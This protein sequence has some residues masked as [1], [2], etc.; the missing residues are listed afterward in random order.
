MGELLVTA[1]LHIKTKTYSL[2]VMY[3]CVFNVDLKPMCDKW[4]Y[5]RYVTYHACYV[6]M[7]APKLRKV[8]LG[9]TAVTELTQGYIAVSS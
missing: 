3:S 4:M 5:T 6:Q 1:A 7:Y 2:F 9:D 8:W